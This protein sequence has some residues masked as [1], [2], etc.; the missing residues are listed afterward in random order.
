MGEGGTYL[1]QGST[2]LGRGIPTL[3][4]PSPLPDLVGGTYLKV[5]YIV[6]WRGEGVP[7]LDQGRDTYLGVPL[8]SPRCEQTPVKTVPSRRTTYAGGNDQRRIPA[9]FVFLFHISPCIIFVPKR[10]SSS[11]C[12]TGLNNLIRLV[13]YP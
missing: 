13:L 5:P 3:G 10:T 6:T 4:Y 1:D 12:N 9:T 2:Y 11:N 7:T 8:P